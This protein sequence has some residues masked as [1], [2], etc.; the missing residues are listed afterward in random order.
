VLLIHGAS[1]PRVTVR[2]SEW[3]EAE[4]RRLGK[5]VRLVAF[6]DEGHRRDYGNWRNAIRHYGEIERFLARCLGG[7]VAAARRGAGNP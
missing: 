7:R 6:R 5:D 4:L 3:M 2:E 1:D